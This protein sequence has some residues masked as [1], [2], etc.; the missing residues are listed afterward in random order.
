MDALNLKTFAPGV[1]DVLAEVIDAPAAGI[2][3]SGRQ[4]CSLVL[5]VYFYLQ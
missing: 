4:G 2:E 3:L 1:V 5:E